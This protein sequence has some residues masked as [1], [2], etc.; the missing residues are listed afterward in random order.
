MGV[1]AA[2][3]PECRGVKELLSVAGL[4]PDRVHWRFRHPHTQ[5]GL[6]LLFKQEA[7]ES[8]IYSY[9]HG[10][11]G[12][13]ALL[14]KSQSI[15][16]AALPGVVSVTK[17]QV[18]HTQLEVG[19]LWDWT[20][21]SQMD[22]LHK[23]KMEMTTLLVSLT[24]LVYVEL[25]CILMGD[26]SEHVYFAFLGIWPESPSFA[27]DGYGPPPPKWKGICQAGVSFGPNNCNGKVIGA[28][29]Y[30]DD[31]EKGLL[32]GEFLSPRDANSHGTHTASTAAGNLV[33]NVSFHGLAAGVAHGGAPRAR[34]AIYKACWGA[35]PTHG[36][37]SRATMM[38]AIDDAI[39][40][41]VDVLSLSIVGPLET[42][43]MLHVVANGITVVCSAGNGGPT[44]QTVDNSCSSPW[45][46][47]VAA[48]TIDR[49]FPTAI[50]LGNNQRIVGQSLYVATEGTDHFYV[51]LSYFGIECD[52]DYINPT[53]VKGKVIFCITPSN[54]SPSNNIAAIVNLL[55]N[56]GGKG[57]IFPQENTDLLYQWEV[58]SK[59]IPVIAVD[60]VVAYQILQYYTST[61]TPKA[62]I[63]STHTTIGS[64]VPAP[65]VAAFSS[66]GPSP[67]YPGVLKPDIAAPGVNILAAAP[68]IAYYKELGVLYHF[69]SGTSMACPHVSGIVALLKSRHPDWSP[70]ALKS[71]LMT[72]ALSTKNTGLPIQADGTLAKIADPFDYG[73]GFVNPKKGR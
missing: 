49:L 6:D 70:A 23:L 72:T 51:V 66:R 64:G 22:Y 37:C 53:D 26:V 30:A 2:S 58:T 46:L 43:G 68:Q 29:W 10:F 4:D 52:P 5:V 55:L 36:S 59:L 34:L 73:A 13:F 28:Q 27:D 11:S 3:A 20:T 35:Y 17:N 18:Y 48:T 15:K 60:L 50:I 7:V 32:D 16:I 61:D 25:A 67:I 14:T 54:L 39:H 41:G 24:Q 71:A 69:D 44:A 45:L 56:K 57:F 1:L 33:H 21:I 8:F 42:P 40:D 63:S 31:V 65:K 19:T 47:A 62:K 12:F 9:R 38:K